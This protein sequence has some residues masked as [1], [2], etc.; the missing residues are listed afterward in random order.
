MRRVVGRQYEPTSRT[1]YPEQLSQQGPP[2]VDMVEDEGEDCGVERFVGELDEWLAEIVNVELG[3][4]ADAGPGEVDHAG[5]LVD[6]NH[7]GAAGDEA[8]GVQA[9]T[10][11]GI[12][13]WSPEVRASSWR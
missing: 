2:V 1:E 9:R 10:A 11:A 6:A 4:V 7:R 12:E 13:H 8:F 3:P 5:T